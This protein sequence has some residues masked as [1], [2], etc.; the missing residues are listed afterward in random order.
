MS[1]NP[2]RGGQ[3][4]GSSSRVHGDRFAD[5]EAIGNKFANGLSGVSVGDF[6][7]FIG[8]EPDLAFATANHGGGEALLSTEVDPDDRPSAREE[9]RRLGIE[10]KAG[11]G[12]VV[13][14]FQQTERTLKSG[15]E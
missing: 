6:A 3:F 15:V 2:S 10:I 14:R 8:I 5:D 9:L 4:P 13:D 7:D 1:T 11:R 12:I